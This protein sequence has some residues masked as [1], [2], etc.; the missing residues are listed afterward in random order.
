MTTFGITI[1]IPLSGLDHHGKQG[2]TSEVGAAGG[3]SRRAVVWGLRRKHGRP[4]WA[5]WQ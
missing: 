2:D 3:R 1:I 4:Q 5:G